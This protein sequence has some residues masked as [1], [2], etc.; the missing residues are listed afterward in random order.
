MKKLLAFLMLCMFV[1]S[2][3]GGTD[4]GAGE[5]AVTVGIVQMME[6]P[7]L[8]LIRTSFLEEM[9]R[10]GYGDIDFD[11]RIGQGDMTSL[12]AIAQMFVGNEVD[13]IMAIATPAAQAA[14]AATGDIP[15]IFA[16]STDPVAAGLVAD[17]DYPDT[18][19]TGTSDII[20]VE[21]I[22]TFAKELVPEARTFGFVYNLGEVNSVSVINNAKEFFALHGLEYREATVTS[23]ADVQQAALSLVG[24]VDA[25]FTPIDNTVASAMP[26]FARVAIDAGLPIFTGA[27]SMVMDGGLATVG[28]DYAILGAETAAMVS[29]VL[30]GAAIADVP[31]KRMED[32]RTIVNRETADALGISLEG[33][34]A[35]V[36]IY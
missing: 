18:N 17:L 7:S 19:V 15:V 29:Q 22:F 13:L 4:G 5:S 6:H 21:S 33:L 3:C 16:A 28:I 36:E 8:D 34:G 24:Q 12:T 35:H 10:L 23:T 1:F 20:C 2:A 31:V 11:V 32:F 27:D 25:F 14:A 30:G 26:V 9:E